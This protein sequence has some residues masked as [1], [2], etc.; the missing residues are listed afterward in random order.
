MKRIEMNIECRSCGGTGLYAGLGEGDGA[1][2]VCHTCKGTGCEHYKLDYQPFT[3]RQDREGIERVYRVNPGIYIGTGNGHTL[4]DFGGMPYEDWREG[5]SWP[6]GS[7]DR[8]HT[9]PAWYYQIADYAKKPNWAKCVGLG[10]TFFNCPHFEDKAKCWAR[11]DE[12]FGGQ[13]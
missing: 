7:E 11:W 2:V 8:Q 3:E 9:C 6:A 10:G 5:A 13:P 1:A 12:E 4:E